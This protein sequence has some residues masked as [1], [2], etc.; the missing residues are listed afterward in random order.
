M[1]KNYSTKAPAGEESKKYPGKEMINKI[2]N[3][4][5]SLECKKNKNIEVLLNLN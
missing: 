3:F 4:S 2:L 5:K 1:Q